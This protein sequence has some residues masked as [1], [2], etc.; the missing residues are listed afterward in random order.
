[1]GV[2]TGLLVMARVKIFSYVRVVF[3]LGSVTGFYYTQNLEV[4]VVFSLKIIYNIFFGYHSDTF[5]QRS[6]IVSKL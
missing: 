1:M 2:P 3:L 5:S 4:K 6:Y